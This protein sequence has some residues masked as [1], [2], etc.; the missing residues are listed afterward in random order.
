MFQFIHAAD[1]H[2]DSPLRGLDKYEGAPVE[3][4]R[5]ATRRAFANLVSLAITEQVDFVILAGDIYDGDWKDYNTGLF[6]VNEVS[7]LDKAGIPVVLLFGNHDAASR[8]TSHLTY[9][10]NTRVF[11]TDKPDKVIFDHLRVA[12]HGQGYAVQAETRNLAAEYPPRVS[13][14][15]NIGVLHT[16]L[17]GR[18][19][20]G[21]Y[22]TCTL[23]ELLARGYE[24]WALGHVHKRE[25][26]NI[27][28]HPRVEFPGNIQGRHVRETGAKGCLLVTVDAHGQAAPEFR[29][30]DVFRWENVA[31]DAAEAGSSAE[32][33]D[34]TAKALADARDQAEGRKLAARIL[35]SCCDRVHRQIAEN[36]A[37][38]RFD[39][40]G[41]AGLSV[42]VEKIKLT[43]VGDKQE[44][45]PVL[46]R[47]ADSE[48]RAVL[49]E[50][51]SDSEAAQALFGA[52]DC[53]K[54]K[55]VLPTEIRGVFGDDRDEIFDLAAM[56]LRGGDKAEED[57]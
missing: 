39:L 14:Y 49:A 53:G 56:L 10:P 37:E 3:A 13:G 15:F 55:K 29:A 41:Q 36:M 57:S 18:E 11:P 4:I 34:A 48:L 45:E 42:W 44:F 28:R 47:D 6:F 31:V 52:G 30:L 51:R 17:E 32:A 46:T 20:H 38:F 35:L 25:S 22:A 8:I 50:Y 40:A 27:D 21:T 43:I 23:A 5:E 26:V 24:Y 12:V 1:I 9:P 54:L 16:A 19:G 2:L 33:L 7:K